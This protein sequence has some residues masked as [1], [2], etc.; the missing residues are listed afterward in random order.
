MH[1]HIANNDVRHGPAF[2]RCKKDGYLLREDR[3][4]ASQLLKPARV[5]DVAELAIKPSILT[6]VTSR[7]HIGIHNHPLK[8]LGLSYAQ[9]KQPFRRRKSS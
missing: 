5:G 2:I 3:V 9:L 6:E 1:M 8:Y 7:A 4:W